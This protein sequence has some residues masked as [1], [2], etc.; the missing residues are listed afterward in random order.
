MDFI[1]SRGGVWMSVIIFA[2]PCK[3][4]WMLH[5]NEAGRMPGAGFV[6]QTESVG[7]Y[8]SKVKSSPEKWWRPHRHASAFPSFTL[9]SCETR[10]NRSIVTVS[11]PLNRE[12]PADDLPAAAATLWNTKHNLSPRENF[13]LM[14]LFSE[15][16]ENINI[17]L[18]SS[19]CKNKVSI[20]NFFQMG[21]C[22]IRAIC[23][24]TRPALISAW[25]I[26]PMQSWDGADQELFTRS[27]WTLIHTLHL[28]ENVLAQS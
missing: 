4:W 24:Q 8:P 13:V 6:I 5:N 21:G 17:Y 16:K 14:F 3:Y 15:Q 23:L 25:F 18:I 19:K 28:E 7:A 9:S 20:L 2:A 26:H 1:F 12:E 22:E 27:H 11:N 10:L